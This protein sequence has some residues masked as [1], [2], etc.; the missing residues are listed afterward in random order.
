M[1]RSRAVNVIDDAVSMRILPGKK[2]GARRRAKGRGHESIAEVSTLSADSIY[3][4][5]LEVGMSGNTEF[6]PAQIVNQD[7]NNIRSPVG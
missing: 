4:W 2:P 7:K 5:C 3:V 6:V 1:T